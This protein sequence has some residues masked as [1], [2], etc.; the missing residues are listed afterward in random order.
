[1]LNRRQFDEALGALDQ[2][3]SAPS[4]RM[5]PLTDL[6]IVR[7]LNQGS[8][9]ADRQRGTIAVP[10]VSILSQLVIEAQSNWARSVALLAQSR[11]DEALAAIEAADGTFSVLA[12]ESIDQRQVLWLGAKIERQRARILLRK[13]DVTGALAALDRAISSLNSAAVDGGIGPTLAETQ[14]ERA[15]VAARAG[16]THSQVQAQFEGAID[17]L[18][19]SGASGSVL[20]PVIEQYLQSLIEE[21]EQQP[22]GTSGDRFFRA[23]QAV[24][25]PAVARQFTQI[26]SIVTADSALAAKVQDRAEIEREIIQLRFQVGRHANRAVGWICRTGKAARRCGDPADRR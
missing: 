19:A 17:S 13:N 24:G 15:A 22:D 11:P 18:I 4:D 14:M 20:P 26:Q 8:E 21:S 5:Q 1:M 7:T 3:V 2:L 9:G 6:A 16:E 10:D 23:I 25:D 12:R